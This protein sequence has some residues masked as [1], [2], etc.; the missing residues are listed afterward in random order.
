MTSKVFGIFLSSNKL[1]DSYTNAVDI[2]SLGV[3]AFLIL[4]GEILFKDSYSLRLYVASNFFFPT[5]VLLVKKI[6]AQ[7]CTFVR[8]LMAPRLEN[9]SRVK[10]CLQ[11]SWLTSRKE[12]PKSEKNQVLSLTLENSLVPNL[13]ITIVSLISF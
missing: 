4:I 2:W 12:A 10:D 9:R 13:S 8:S 11:H 3:I 5:N 1:K 6:S 7:E